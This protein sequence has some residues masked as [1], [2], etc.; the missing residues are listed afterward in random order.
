MIRPRFL[1]VFHL[2]ADNTKIYLLSTAN[3]DILANQKYQLALFLIS[4][5]LGHFS[6]LDR[7]NNLLLFKLTI[8]TINCDEQHEQNRLLYKE[9]SYDISSK[10]A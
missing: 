7:A 6:T 3:I 8:F 10:N 2:T 5:L 1:I 9:Q 4:D